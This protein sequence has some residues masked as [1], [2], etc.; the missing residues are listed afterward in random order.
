MKSTNFAVAALAVSLLI[1][2]PAKAAETIAYTPAAFAATQKAGKPTLVEIHTN[3]CG[4]CKA[5]ARILGEI[6]NQPD[7]HNL[8]VLHVDF[9]TQKDAVKRFGANMQ[10]TLITF[11]HGKET[12][13]SVGDTNPETISALVAKAF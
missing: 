6:E 1:G 2:A 8:V 4:T 9:D 12:G 13:R 10:S 3:W 5:Q 11:K 7:F